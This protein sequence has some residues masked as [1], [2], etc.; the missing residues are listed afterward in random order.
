MAYVDPWP[1]PVV[2]VETQVYPKHRA[3]C[4]HTSQQSSRVQRLLNALSGV[5]DWIANILL[6][7]RHRAIFEGYTPS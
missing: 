1:R 3:A 7:L 4:G 5:A 2:A 6:K